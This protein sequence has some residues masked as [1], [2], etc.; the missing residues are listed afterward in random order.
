MRPTV[1]LLIAVSLFLGACTPAV[2]ATPTTPPTATL[3][4]PIEETVDI[5]LDSTKIP[6]CLDLAE[7]FEIFVT[8]VFRGQQQQQSAEFAWRRVGAN[9]PDVEVLNIDQGVKFVMGLHQTA[10]MTVKV[11]FETDSGAKTFS[12][13][14]ALFRFDGLDGQGRACFSWATLKNPSGR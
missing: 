12:E 10:S 4:Q 5:S 8:T 14:V 1:A 7:T 9:S 13:K 3:L 2:V 11:N 6:G